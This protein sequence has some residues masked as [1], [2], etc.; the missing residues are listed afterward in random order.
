MFLKRL[1]SLIKDSDSIKPVDA[2]VYSDHARCNSINPIIAK[3]VK[4]L[5][6]F[7]VF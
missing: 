4:L 3:D 6:E 2:Q 5:A 1:E 7:Q